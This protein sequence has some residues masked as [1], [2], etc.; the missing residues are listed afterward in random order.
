MV[1][2]VVDQVDKDNKEDHHLETHHQDNKEDNKEDHHLETHHQDNKED[3]KVDHHLVTHHQ[4]NKEDNKVDH[5]L[6]THHQD[7]DHKEIHH[8]LVTHHKDKDLKEIHQTLQMQPHLKET[9]KHLVVYQLLVSH[10]QDMLSQVQD[11]Q[12]SLP[13]QYQLI[14]QVLV[15]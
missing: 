11:Y 10:H 14:H 7:K 8:H 4:D 9:Y 12:L 2:Q 15:L 1:D 5:H 6:V 13:A 3:N